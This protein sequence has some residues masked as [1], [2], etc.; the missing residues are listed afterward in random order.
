MKLYNISNCYVV[1]SH[2]LASVW[3]L[4]VDLERS[5]PLDSYHAPKA[6]LVLANKA[7]SLQG[8]CFF[9]VN[10]EWVLNVLLVAMKELVSWHPSGPGACILPEVLVVNRLS[11][12][13]LNII[14]NIK[15]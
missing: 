9:I 6:F 2:P 7:E 13:H 12:G 10:T 1:F 8:H 11:F 15:G 14:L 5:N 4:L 3:V